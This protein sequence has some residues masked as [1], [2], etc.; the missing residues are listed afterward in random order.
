KHVDLH[1][2]EHT[3]VRIQ[4][5]A[6]EPMSGLVSK[7]VKAN[8]RMGVGACKKRRFVSFG[9]CVEFCKIVVRPSERAGKDEFR[10]AGSR[11]KQVKECG[12]AVDIL[13]GRM[14]VEDLDAVDIGT[15]G[16][17][18]FGICNERKTLLVVQFLYDI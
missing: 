10:I 15:A 17:E 5:Y 18:S 12:K 7:Q 9:V 13:C 16:V 14:K 4:F 1:Y 2:P 6:E 3:F 11:P 8:V